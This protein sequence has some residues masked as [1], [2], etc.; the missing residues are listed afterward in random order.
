VN[1]NS[2]FILTS[3]RLLPSI[4]IHDMLNGSQQVAPQYNPVMY[5]PGFPTTVHLSE[6][7]NLASLTSSSASS[8]KPITNRR[9]GSHCPW[10]SDTVAFMG[11]LHQDAC[12]LRVELVKVSAE[13]A[14]LKT[15]NSKLCEDL[16]KAEAEKQELKLHIERLQEANSQIQNDQQRRLWN[17][18]RENSATSR[19]LKTLIGEK[20]SP[21]S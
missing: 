11:R 9:K 13:A 2:D 8:S 16:E 12:N 18:E 7:E 3:K 20:A 1:M 6:A 15:E 5:E 21:S 4:N 10:S 19:T 17:L 14:S